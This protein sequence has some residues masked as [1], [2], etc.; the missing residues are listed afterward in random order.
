MSIKFQF[1]AAGKGD[2]ILI[3]TQSRNILIDG[4]QK[5]R[6][7]DK[8]I[9]KLESL[10]LVILTHIDD[11]HIKGLIELL[12][13]EIRTKIKS[14]WFNP[15]DKATKF[16]SINRTN[17]TSVKQGIVFHQLVK[18]MKETDDLFNYDDQ[19]YIEAKPTKIN[20]FEEISIELLSPTRKKLK[21]LD[22]E[23]DNYCAKHEPDST[24][25][26]EQVNN[27][28]TCE[29]LASNS[30]EKDTSPANGASIAFILTYQ[31]NYCFLLLAD[32]HIDVIVT[33]LKEKGFSENNKLKI[34]F[35][36]LSHHGSKHNINQDFL[37]L[38]ETDIFIISTNG[39]GHEHPD[40]E[41]LCQIVKNLPRI[42]NKFLIFYFNYDDNYNRCKDY[43]TS[44]DFK[45]YNFSLKLLEK[46][47]LT[48]GE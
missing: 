26:G 44:Q 1:L 19:I 34:N 32:A 37:N 36:K 39:S 4:G 3:S 33:S 17:E 18:E 10:D 8:H 48:F 46:N 13:K 43:F 27:Q 2:A 38:I 14:I 42:Q 24:T 11:D 45:E 29:K 12:G 9:S 20:L 30:F 21:I 47:G 6:F 7:I 41:T 40:K 16:S 22:K 28:E 25:S 31:E 5:Y 35:V 15:F 23:Y